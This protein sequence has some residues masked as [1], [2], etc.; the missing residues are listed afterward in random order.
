LPPI[1]PEARALIERD[2]ERLRTELVEAVRSL[3]QRSCFERLGLHRHSSVEDVQSAYEK[4]RRETAAR[5]ALPQHATFEIRLRHEE[6]ML[7]LRRA[8]DALI[9]PIERDEY[10][11]FLGGAEFEE[12]GL[13]KM[14]LAERAFLEGR[15]SF[16]Q[17]DFRSAR[18][19]FEIASALAPEEGIYL[20]Y[21][22]FSSYSAEADDDAARRALKDL[23]RAQDL[24]PRLDRAYVFAAMLHEQL[25]SRELAMDNMKK[26]LGCN[27]DCVEALGSIRAWTPEP[28]KKSGFLRIF[29][30]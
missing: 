21:R 27:P 14:H 16:E 20:A 13:S 26:A 1:S 2:L 19:Q 11:R 12:R 15:S 18:S 4:V 8:R 3:E 30:S 10:V 23:E 17:R 22:A 7:L 24:S 28:E 25:G 29:T 6:L 9:H 5:F